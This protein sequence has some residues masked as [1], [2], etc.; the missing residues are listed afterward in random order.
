MS[1]TESKIKGSIRAHWFVL[2]AAVVLIGDIALASLDSWS[3][4]Q[5]LEAGILF[6]LSVVIPALYLWC[7]RSRGKAAIV[8][9]IAL[10]CLGI[11]VAGHVVPNEHHQVLSAVGFI[12]YVGLA[13][14]VVIEL[15]LAVMIFRAAFRRDIEAAPTV[16]ATAKDAGM[17][18]WAAR[19][20]A[21]EAS[22]WRKAWDAIRR[23]AGRS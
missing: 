21:W 2:A 20:M 10:S 3:D 17:P 12:R 19:L 7:Y 22:L 9:A 11:W 23:M 1:M 14:L 4:P 13:V 15:K 16:L 8:R 18:E 6:D 5:L